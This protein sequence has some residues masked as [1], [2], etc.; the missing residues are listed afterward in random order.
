MPSRH[1]VRCV[2]FALAFSF[3]GQS[4]SAQISEADR[5]Q[6]CLNNHEAI[7]RLSAELQ[8]GTYSEEQIARART[9]IDAI[10]RINMGVAQY[11]GDDE[12]LLAQIQEIG[13]SVLVE[14]EPVNLGC[15][16]RMIRAIERRIA[17]G[18][19]GLPAR[20]ELERRW[21]EHRNNMIALRCDQPYNATAA[22]G[23]NP[24]GQAG[25]EVRS[26]AGRYY[27][28]A[29]GRWLQ[30]TQDGASFSWISE[31][32][33]ERGTGTIAGRP[34]YE[35]LT[36]TVTDPSGTRS[37]TGPVNWGV[38]RAGRVNAID[39]RNYNSWTGY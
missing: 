8:S 29:T 1:S 27:S 6:R 20:R 31:D 10:T 13:R 38:A 37:I 23:V 2:A 4:A 17:E 19:A 14:C 12:P 5:W 7:T 35:T 21:A 22:V 15:G 28:S 30:L 24:G 39:W 34:G 11:D 36:A 26:I 18:E 3:T 32:G 16:V 33:L 9:A 25:G